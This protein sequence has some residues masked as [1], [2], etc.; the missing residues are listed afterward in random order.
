MVIFA[1]KFLSGQVNM[2]E[3][4]Q[5]IRADL[6][7]LMNGTVSKSMREKGLDYK[8]NWGVDIPRL[9]QLATHYEADADL[10]AFLWRQQTREL[11]ILGT[12][13]Y[14]VDEFDA[15]TAERW[16]KEIPNH[17]IREQVCMNLF[18]KLSFADQLVQHW[19]NSPDDGIRSTG[20]WLLARLAIANPS[21]LDGID[22]DQVM[23]NAVSDLN[24]DSYFLRLSAQNALK[25]LG[26]VSKEWS[27][28]ILTGIQDFHL[29]D[30]A[31]K[32]EIYD[33]LS[34]EFSH[35]PD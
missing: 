5:R 23:G 26:R 20:Y 19:T 9:R 30:D 7:R 13:L 2:P 35:F 4:V 28:K 14:P 29:S 11:K 10:G 12:L 22:N 17:E 24:S 21:L 3:I 34:F 32:N 8:F 16:V 6:R 25:F 1:L 15:E 31:V 18:Q 27:Q 33:N